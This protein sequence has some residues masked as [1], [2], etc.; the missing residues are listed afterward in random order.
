MLSPSS[1]L[2][3]CLGEDDVGHCWIS[4]ETCSTYSHV[5]ERR[6]ILDGLQ[7][8]VRCACDCERIVEKTGSL[9]LPCGVTDP[10]FGWVVYTSTVPHPT[11]ACSP[12]VLSGDFLEPSDSSVLHFLSSNDAVDWSR[13][14]AARDPRCLCW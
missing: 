1:V 12:R 7:V 5:H 6:R 2:V 10:H 8:D 11:S 4:V 13:K 3:C 14:R 9:F